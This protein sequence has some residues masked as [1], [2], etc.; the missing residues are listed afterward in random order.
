[1]YFDYAQQ[2]AGI[3]STIDDAKTQKENAELARDQKL[4]DKK[5]KNLEAQLKQV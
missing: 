4:N 2:V 1:M 5:K 3:L